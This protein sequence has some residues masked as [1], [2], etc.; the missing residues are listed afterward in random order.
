MLT[1][2]KKIL[3]DWVDETNIVIE[4]KIFLYEKIVQ[5]KIDESEIFDFRGTYN[6][7][8]SKY[9]T[10]IYQLGYKVDVYTEDTYIPKQRE[11][12]L[13]NLFDA[14]GIKIKENKT[15]ET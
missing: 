8:A 14:A 2:V 10:Q 9:I 15:E 11:N 7:I 3:Q 6:E 4:A 1:S 13:M 12:I 5:I